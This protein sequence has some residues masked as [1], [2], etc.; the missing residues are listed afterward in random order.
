MV[1]SRAGSSAT[2]GVDGSD[3]L[4]VVGQHPARAAAV[5]RHLD[6]ADVPQRLPHRGQG[7]AEPPLEVERGARTEPAQP[8]LDQLRPGDVL[9]DRRDRLPQPV[10]RQ[11][12]GGSRRRPRAEVPGP[13]DRP[14]RLQARHH[15]RH[16]GERPRPGL[17]VAVRD[18]PLQHR[19]ALAE[20]RGGERPVGQACHGGR[21]HL[22]EPPRR[23]LDEAR[24]PDLLLQP[25]PLDAGD[26]VARRGL[27]DRQQVAGR[28]RTASGAWP[29]A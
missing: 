22:V 23:V 8:P 9:G 19:L 13:H 10:G 29:G 14:G 5:Q 20:L 7:R 4:G 12:P 2:Q 3:G 28:P 26:L 24:L 6:R 27:H 16:H 11:R 1:G 17:P 25:T 18:R 15:A 21:R